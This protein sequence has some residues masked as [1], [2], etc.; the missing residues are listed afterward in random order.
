MKTVGNNSLDFA[1]YS[2]VYH[3]TF[4]SPCVLDYILETFCVFIFPFPIPERCFSFSSIWFIHF[5]VINNSQMCFCSER[6]KRELIT[7]C[8]GHFS[9]PYLIIP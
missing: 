5:R 1:H 9:L 6:M 3:S 8:L 4:T 2:V 7:Y